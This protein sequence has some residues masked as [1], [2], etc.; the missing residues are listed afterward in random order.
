MLVFIV[1][2]FL[3]KDD[4]TI[5]PS[6]RRIRK[7]ARFRKDYQATEEAVKEFDSGRFHS[8]PLGVNCWHFKYV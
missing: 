1:D 4:S 2:Q 8:F 6:G 3:E 7:P 5:T